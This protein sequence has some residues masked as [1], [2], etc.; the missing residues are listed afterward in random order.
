MFIVLK[1]VKA[2]FKDLLV[3]TLDPPG[4]ADGPVLTKSPE[5]LLQGGRVH[6]RGRQ[7]SQEFRPPLGLIRRQLDLTL[8]GKTDKQE[9]FFFSSVGTYRGSR[10]VR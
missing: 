2:T 3:L 5:G 6:L 7:Y 1:F 8:L 9:G 4:P 10:V